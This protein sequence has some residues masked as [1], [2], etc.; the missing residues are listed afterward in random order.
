VE[1]V[2]FDQRNRQ[3]LATGKLLLV[4]NAIDQA[5]ATIRLKALFP[6]EDEKLWPGDFVNARLLLETRASAIAVPAA[7]VQRGPQGLFAWIVTEKNTAEPRPIEVGPT[8][9]D[10]TIVT[11]GLSEGERVITD[12]Q[13]KVSRGAAVSVASP[14]SADKL[15]DAGGQK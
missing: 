8:T 12:G 5:T 7:A 3:A 11:S 14:R 15:A 10:V 1:V 2:A 4:D 9:G 13:Y 6:N